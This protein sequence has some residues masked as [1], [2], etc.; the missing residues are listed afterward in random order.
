MR[1]FYLSRAGRCYSSVPRETQHAN[2]V[3]RE[4]EEVDEMY[5]TLHN[6]ASSLMNKTLLQQA[7][8]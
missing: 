7:V 8:Q 4:K 5:E 2:A 1:V 6:L 3:K